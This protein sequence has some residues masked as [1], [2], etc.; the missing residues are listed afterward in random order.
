MLLR[1][2]EKVWGRADA[3]ATKQLGSKQRVAANLDDGWRRCVRAS[4]EHVLKDRYRG[5]EGRS[6]V[7]MERD[8]V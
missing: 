8:E 7:V 2:E 4:W 5:S 3:L 6:V 1:E